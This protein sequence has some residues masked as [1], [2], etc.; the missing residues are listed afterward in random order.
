MIENEKPTAIFEIMRSRK[1]AAYLPSIKNGEK[2]AQ[3]VFSDT[4]VPS[5]FNVSVDLPENRK[6][7]YNTFTSALAILTHEMW[8]K[9][10]NTTLEYHVSE[11][12]VLELLRVLHLKG[13]LVSKDV[14]EVELVRLHY[15]SNRHSNDIL[16]VN[17][18]TT[19]DCNLNCPYCFEGVVQT[20]NKGKTMT[21][22]T[23]NAVVRYIDKLATGKK[24][25]HINWFGGEPLLNI[26]AIMRMSSQLIPAFD[27]AGIKYNVII[28]TNG[29]L[30]SQVVVNRL[31]ECKVSM[32]QVTVD[33]PKATKRDK[34]GLD[35]I[36][37][38]F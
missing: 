28:I 22:E 9:Y 38:R 23:E 30:L 5:R 36:V 15:L 21:R 18:L 24:E 17:I 2:R 34:R 31:Y 20:I 25:V 13:F 35:N 26:E 4:W 16:G 14:D 32:A 6:A 33:V 10:L 7:V 12:P 3:E 19:L 1:T 27:K 11:E 37:L 8:R 29:T